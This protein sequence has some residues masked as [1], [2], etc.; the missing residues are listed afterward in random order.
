MDENLKKEFDYDALMECVR[1]LSEKH[2]F[3]QFSYLTESVMGKGI[4]M[5]TLGA[6]KKE[7]YY[8]GAHHGAE[9]ITAAV[10]I[11]FLNDFCA[12][13]SAGATVFGMNLEYI[14]K[15]RTL[16][17]IPMLNP[18]GVDISAGKLSRDSLWYERLV[19]M[20][21]ASDDFSLW[22]ANANGVDLNHNYDAGFEE[23][24]QIENSLGI[25]VGCATRYSGERPESEPETGALCNFLRFNSPTAL[26]TL[27]TQGKEI[28]YK[29]GSTCPTA[30]K[31]AAVRLA[32]LTGYTLSTPVKEAAFGGL[33]DFC[34]QK[35]GIPAFT[36][37]CG[38]GRNPLPPRDL[39]LIYASLREALFTFPTMF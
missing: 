29:S 38:R 22:Q 35:L 2:S 12:L 9:R 11:C 7:I 18:D 33:T 4:P 31:F 23:Y 37:E 39:S 28:Y 30:S 3:L 13:A 27:H 36:I 24:K 32:R 26:M 25:N 16:H 17:I 6:G 19:R 21:N 10:L 5:L 1:K 34:I 20:N 14:M 15:S 8:V